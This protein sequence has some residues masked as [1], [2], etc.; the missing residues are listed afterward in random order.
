MSTHAAL[1]PWLSDVVALL[2]ALALLAGLLGILDRFVGGRMRRRLRSYLGVAALQERVDEIR[3][4]SEQHDEKLDQLHQE[5]S[6]T[7]VADHDIAVAVN[8]LSETVCE[9][10]D[11]PEDE[12]PPELDTERMAERAQQAGAAWPGEF[13]R[14]GEVLDGD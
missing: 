2:T 13:L 8:D 3:D 14:G 7:M 6:V 4:Q 5:H 10:H 11:V 1:W 9:S 12:R